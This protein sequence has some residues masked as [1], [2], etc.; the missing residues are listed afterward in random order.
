M[1]K[2]LI[3]KNILTY[4]GGDY[5]ILSHEVIDN[6]FVHIITESTTIAFIPKD[7]EINGVV[8]ETIGEIIKYIND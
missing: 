2:I 8:A 3:N 5:T 6:K 7:T 4:R 1:E